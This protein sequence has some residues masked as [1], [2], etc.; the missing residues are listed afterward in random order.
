[1]S[2]SGRA[3]GN[4]DA[5]FE[6]PFVYDG[7]VVLPPDARVARPHFHGMKKSKKKKTL[8]G[9]ILG[10]AVFVWAVYWTL[11]SG[12]PPRHVL[13][14]APVEFGD[15]TVELPATGSIDAVNVVDVGSVVSGR[16]KAM[17]A[18]YNDRVKAGQLLAEI[19]DDVYRGAYLQAK[20][21]LD[22]ATAAV[23]T[24]AAGLQA[25]R[26]DAVRAAAYADQTGALWKQAQIDYNRA[27]KLL[28]DGIVT[29]ADF[30]RAEAAYL[31]ARADTASAKALAQE[32]QSK[33]KAAEAALAE[34][35]ATVEQQ[36][37]RAAAARQNLDY[38]R[39][40]SP[41]DGVV[42]SRNMD[43]GQTVAARYQ[44]PSLFHI[45]QDLTHMYVYTK[46]DSS[47]VAKVRPGLPATFTVNAFPGE[48]FAGTLKVL[49]INP[50]ATL[51]VTRAIGSSSMFQRTLSGGT[52]VGSTSVTDTLNTT[53]T[54]GVSTT[55]SSTGSSTSGTA[56]S[57]T[58][59]A[60]TTAGA[61]STS[62][63]PAAA[64]LN[65]VV[66]YDAL[67][68][69]RNPEEKLLPG[70][71]AYVTI[72]IGAVKSTLK[73]PSAAL[74]FSPHIPAGE[75]QRLLEEN[76]L[77]ENDPMVWVVTGKRENTKYRPVRVK[78]GLTDYVFTAVESDQLRPGMQVGTRTTE[79]KTRT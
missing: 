36:A 5:A 72:P 27:Q 51:P 19:E 40:L 78:P 1:M 57:P 65:T 64:N 10:L 9:G 16:V 31:S 22:M 28:A 6:R 50:N 46:M 37:A 70:M 2:G 15:L 71:T 62:S 44:A 47:D 4:R 63:P 7:R 74:R 48:T 8:A 24:A 20:A 54:S 58:P 13:E 12:P 38:C 41:V 39:I 17:Y 11:G 30:E 29:K 79:A 18:D 75:K 26:D 73:V 68:E 23:H 60:G 45:A 52:T 35:R 53:A 14:T 3:A 56:G 32:A 21:D 67:I 61:S 43:V 42:V 49:R 59:G 69:F 33:V 55:G 66:V 77:K 76:G 34:A 25:T